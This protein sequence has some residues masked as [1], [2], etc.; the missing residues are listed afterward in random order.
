MSLA[1]AKVWEV[2]DDPELRPA[3]L[4]AQTCLLWPHETNIW[5]LTQCCPC[6]EPTVPTCFVTSSV[7]LCHRGCSSTSSW[8]VSKTTPMWRRSWAIALLP[9]A[10]RC[11][12]QARVSQLP[13][14]L[15]TVPQQATLTPTWQ[16]SSW[17]RCSGTWAFTLWVRCPMAAAGSADCC[18][19][20]L[21]CALFNQKPLC[22]TI[23]LY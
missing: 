19:W 11:F 16:R 1:S 14:T 4:L 17:R 15:R 6:H 22:C 8:P 9:M 20:F 5:W 10:P 23:L 2:C 21:K 3:F 18:Y 13:P 12:H 7:D